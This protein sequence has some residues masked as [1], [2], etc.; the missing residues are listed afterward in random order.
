V[1]HAAALLGS[2]GPAWGLPSSGRAKAAPGHPWPAAQG[3]PSPCSPCSPCPGQAKRSAAPG[4][5]RAH[6]WPAEEEDGG[7]AEDQVRDQLRAAPDGSA[8]AAGQADDTPSAVAHAADAV[9]RAVD[10]G[11]VVA[12][13]HAHLR[14]GAQRS[15]TAAARGLRGPAAAGRWPAIPAALQLHMPG[16]ACAAGAGAAACCCRPWQPLPRKAGATPRP[17]ATATPAPRPAPA[18]CTALR[19]SRPPR[20][21]PHLIDCVLEVLVG[22]GVLV[23]PHVARR[24]ARDRR[25]AQVHDDLEQLEE[26]RVRLEHAGD[27][28]GQQCHQLQALLDLQL[29][30][31]WRLGQ[32]RGCTAGWRVVLREACG[33]APSA[34]PGGWS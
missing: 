31:L 15:A 21:A 3:R 11:A 14:A 26:L 13:E 23:Q 28:R 22:D 7:A 16:A 6:P 12:A 19:S 4:Q 27:A 9:Q 1:L 33:A 5:R 34:V 18:H 25:P 10:A 29:P 2:A 32:R 20:A 17:L 24:E 30:V 8:H